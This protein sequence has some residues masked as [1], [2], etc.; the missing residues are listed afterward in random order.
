MKWSDEHCFLFA[1]SFFVVDE[2]EKGTK[3]KYQQS[4]IKTPYKKNLTYGKLQEKKST[5]D[6]W[7]RGYFSTQSKS[8]RMT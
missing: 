6:F 5:V 8:M 4:S 1:L 7:C 3:N 2:T